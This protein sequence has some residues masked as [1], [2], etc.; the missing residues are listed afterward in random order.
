ME[1]RR[2]F[3]TRRIPQHTEGLIAQMWLSG[4]WSQVELGRMFGVSQG[5]VS[6]IIARY[7]EQKEAQA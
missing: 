1:V 7:S 5:Y 6:K 2:G 3:V 4:V